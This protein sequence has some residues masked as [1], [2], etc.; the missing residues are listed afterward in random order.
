MGQHT[1]ENY[2]ICKQDKEAGLGVILILCETEI[3][4][5]YPD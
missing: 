5:S 3:C 1:G 4:L 2:W